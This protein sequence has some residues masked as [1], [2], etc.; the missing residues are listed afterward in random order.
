MIVNQANLGI[1]TTGF[2]TAFASGFRGVTPT[3][4]QVTTLIP[5]TTSEEKY[6]W[7]GQFPRLREWVWDR[8]VWDMEV[9]DYTIRNRKFESTVGVKRDHI[10]DDQYGVYSTIFQE[11]GFAAATHPDELVFELL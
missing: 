4:S 9:H 8:H 10:E 7:L 2:R 1:L 11:L 3:W 5:S 6:G